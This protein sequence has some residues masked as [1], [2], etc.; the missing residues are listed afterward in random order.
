[1]YC[2]MIRFDMVP[3]RLKEGDEWLE[4]VGVPFWAAQEGVKSVCLYKD[5]FS[6]FPRRTLLIEIES[7]DLLQKHL[8]S[9]ARLERRAA[10]LTYVANLTSPIMELVACSK[11]G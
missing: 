8:D 9:P 2:W 1:M 7:A 4:K 5:A 6:S 11:K 10:F 3:E